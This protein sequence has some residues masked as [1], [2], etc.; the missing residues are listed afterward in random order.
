[1]VAGA[2]KIQLGTK[3]S[4]Q[5][6]NFYFYVPTPLPGGSFT[7]K[8]LSIHATNGNTSFTFLIEYTGATETNPRVEYPAGACPGSGVPYDKSSIYYN[9]GSLPLEVNH[10]YVNSAGNVAI[11]Y[12]DR[13]KVTLT[14]TFT[15]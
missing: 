10:C 4:T 8:P 2:F 15:E 11:C 13:F 12:F 14:K 5:T 6:K 7:M 9:G 1:L 3:D